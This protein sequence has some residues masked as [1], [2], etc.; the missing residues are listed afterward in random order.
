MFESLVYSNTSPPAFCGYLD[1]S[2]GFV[3]KMWF[4]TICFLFCFLSSWSLKGGPPTEHR[5]CT[6]WLRK[7]KDF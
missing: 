4:P 2:E 6:I 5:N 3:L 7:G 1:T